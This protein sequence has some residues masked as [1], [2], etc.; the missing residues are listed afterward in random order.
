[1]TEEPV[2]PIEEGPDDADA[3]LLDEQRV[4]TVRCPNCGAAVYEEAP[5]C[6]RCKQWLTEPDNR[7]LAGHRWWWIA[8]AIAGIAAFV[9][10]YAI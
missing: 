6:P 8:L 3:D 4:M 2:D 7:P 5:Q 10:V 1:M 9:F